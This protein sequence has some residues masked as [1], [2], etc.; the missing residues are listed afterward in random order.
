MNI[1]YIPRWYPN[2]FDPQLGV[3]TLKHAKAASAY[4]T[5][6][7][8]YPCAD[9]SMQT[10]YNL[11]VT[12]EDTLITIVAYY[13]QSNRICNTF[14]YFRAFTLA[15][16]L[17]TKR[18]WKPDLI[19]AHVLLR[20][21]LIAWLLSWFWKI[22]YIITEHWTGYVYGA[23]EKKTMV[24]KSLCRF[25]VKQAKALTVVSEGLLNG[26]SKQKITNNNTRIISNVVDIPEIKND[27]ERQIGPIRMLTVADLVDKNKNI[28]SII[29]SLNDL[30]LQLPDF[31]YHIIGGG[32]DGELLISLAKEKK[33]FN[34]SVF[35]HG[36]Q[37]NDY[38]LNFIQS[39]DFLIVNSNVET[40]SVVTAEAIACGK[41]VIATRSGGPEYFVTKK[42]GILIEKQDNDGLK[43][44]ILKMIPAYR[45]FDSFEMRDEMKEKF[46]A[47]AIG[48]QLSGL[49]NQIVQL[50]GK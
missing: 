24:Y 26:M 12:E 38:V 2:K 45:N 50:N 28:S 29:N 47:D 39:I 48:K 40:F 11:E 21:F 3:F 27:I 23:F 42:N 7:V 49:Y 15:L 10:N 4:F 41:P 22:P 16:N 35:F 36:R 14:R 30:Q 19:H 31:E 33:M 25:F 8:I 37:S 9:N 43:Q 13:H 17:L 18:F 20:T 34:K 32:K 44:A 46:C 6:A 1:L 5:I